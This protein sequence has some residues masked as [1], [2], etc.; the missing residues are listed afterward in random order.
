MLPQLSRSVQPEYT[1]QIPGEVPEYTGE[2]TVKV[3]AEQS[4]T[5]LK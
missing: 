4:G 5:N 3:P 1:G 2:V